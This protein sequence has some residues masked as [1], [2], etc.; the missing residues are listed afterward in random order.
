MTLLDTDVL[1]LLMAGNER[2]AQRVHEAGDVAITIISRIEVLQGRFASILKAADGAKLLEA[3]DWL[4]RNEAFI[5]D[6]EVV[7]FDATATG[8]F[9]RLRQDKK[10]K[11]IGRADLLIACI[12]LAHGATLVTRNLRHFRQVPGLKLENWAD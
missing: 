5:Q 11:K 3:Q 10:L 1:S 8:E 9:D 12:A 6:L 4:G 7:P 2:L